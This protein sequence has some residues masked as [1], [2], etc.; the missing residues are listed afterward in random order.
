MGK[1][2]TTV[3]R[4][5]VQSTGRNVTKSLEIMELTL[6]FGRQKTVAGVLTS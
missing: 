4:E 5:T 3:L 1:K 2:H 6:N